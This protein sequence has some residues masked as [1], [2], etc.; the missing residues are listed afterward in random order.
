MQEE[1]I[2][3]IVPIYNSAPYLH[4]CIDS[5]INQT[6]KN[7]EIILV[8]DG[9]TDSSPKICNSYAK[10][11]NRIRVIHQQNAG[12]I[13]ARIAGLK[14]A[15]GKYTGFVDSDDWI[16]Q[17]MYEYLYYHMGNTDLATCGIFRYDS[18]GNLIDRWVDL[19]EEG[20]YSSESEMKAFFENLVISSAYNGGTVIG[21]ISNNNVSKLFKT[22]LAKSLMEKANVLVHYEED[23]LF[24]LLYAFHCHSVSISHRCL[25]HYPDNT[26]S[27]CHSFFPH[28]LAERDCFYDVVSSA[29]RGHPY[30]NTLLEQF[31]RRFLAG[32]VTGMALR[33]QF[34]PSV[35][36]PVWYPPFMSKL[37]GKK[38]VLFGAGRVGQS[39]A[40]W[41]HTQKIADIILWLDNKPSAKHIKPVSELTGKNF[42]FILIAVKQSTWAEAIKEQLIT[43][44]IDKGKILWEEPMN[45]VNS[46]LLNNSQSRGGVQQ[47]SIIASDRGSSAV[48]LERQM[49]LRHVKR[50]ETPIAHAPY[51][52]SYKEVA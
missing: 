43:S 51:A 31:Q 22:E 18:E 39:Y 40:Q 28:Y 17:D 46:I 44:G 32:T 7:L 25:Y 12:Q 15:S 27:V 14:M 33:L 9:S 19:L 52:P 5:I 1:L 24:N 37:C 10:K 29:L 26:T 20:V 48:A 47:Y 2:S 36:F 3:V 21:G 8:D 34:F 42:D 11:D 23:L 13:A 41:I 16:E 4:R 45:I 49:Y 30:E 35:A 50:S 38:I 6:Y